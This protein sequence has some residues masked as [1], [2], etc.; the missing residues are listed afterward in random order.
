MMNFTW[1]TSRVSLAFS[2]SS[3]RDQGDL[4]LDVFGLVDQDGPIIVL[5]DGLTG[6]G[7]I[8]GGVLTHLVLRLEP[9]HVFPVLLSATV[10]HVVGGEGDDPLKSL[11]IL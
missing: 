3:Q 7:S 6:E 10:N 8:A 4:L 5:D 2:F 11:V 1:I 9:L